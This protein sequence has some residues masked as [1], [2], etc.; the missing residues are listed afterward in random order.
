MLLVVDALISPSEGYW[1]LAAAG[2]LLWA[3]PLLIWAYRV[4]ADA[5]RLRTIL[6]AGLGG[7]AVSWA[8][9]VAVMA[10]MH[11]WQIS[12]DQRS[13]TYLLIFFGCLGACVVAGMTAGAVA[14][15]LVQGFR[16]LAAL[17]ASGTASLAGLAG[18]YVLVSWDGCV[19]PLDTMVNSCAWRPVAGW[20]FF[21]TFGG[22][23]LGFGS[24]AAAAVATAL[25]ILTTLAAAAQ[26]RARSVPATP[27]QAMPTLQAQSVPR[28]RHSS[29]LAER[30]AIVALTAMTAT[31][32][33]VTFSIPGADIG[34]PGGGGSG[35]A[36]GSPAMSQVTQLDPTS[37]ASPKET[38]EM[39]AAWLNYGGAHLATALN[40]V[41]AKLGDA[42][43][44]SAA[45]VFR[46]ANRHSVVTNA[47]FRTAEAPAASACTAMIHAVRSAE[48]YFPVPSPSLQRQWQSMLAGFM[49]GAQRCVE[50]VRTASLPELTAS[51]DDMNQATEAWDHVVTQLTSAAGRFCKAC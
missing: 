27:G 22:L 32:L 51:L 29:L 8:G 16:L 13:A 42:M 39:V 23:A 49:T 36:S 46:G 35:T 43:S 37:S 14:A 5:L 12:A 30:S 31:M 4:R 11:S 6:L 24:T 7:G 45:E 40:N 34:N 20:E 44:R 50:A 3:A 28:A 47:Q 48:A 26:R 1:L 10:Y 33:A 38:G 21:R 19:A 15:A 17:V 25:V 41:N 18:V 9:A 2:A